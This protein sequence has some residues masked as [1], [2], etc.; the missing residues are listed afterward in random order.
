MELR[1]GRT[2]G[3]WESRRFQN[4]AQLVESINSGALAPWASRTARSWKRRV[5]PVANVSFFIIKP[6]LKLS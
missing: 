4:G 3:E 6:Y 2:E 1:N 5:L